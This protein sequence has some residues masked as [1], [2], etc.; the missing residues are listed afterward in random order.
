MH[1]LY[2]SVVLAGSS[3]LASGYQC[4]G[5]PPDVV[6]QF[7]PKIVSDEG[8]TTVH[9][10][11]KWSIFRGEEQI[12]G[13][14]CLAT[15]DCAE[16]QGQTKKRYEIEVTRTTPGPLGLFRYSKDT[17][18]SRD[19]MVCYQALGSDPDKCE[20][21]RQTGR[22][23]QVVE[24]DVP[25]A[26]APSI[27]K[28]ISPAKVTVNTLTSIEFT[29]AS[30]GDKAAFID[31][32]FFPSCDANTALSMKDVGTGHAHFSLK[33][34]EYVLCYRAANAKDAVMQA[35]ITLRV[36]P[37]GVTSDMLNLWQPA[38]GKLDCSQLSLAPFCSFLELET[39][40]QH[41][42]VYK[43]IG[44]RCRIFSDKYP[45]MCDL[46]RATA[47]PDDICARGKCEGAPSVCW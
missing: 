14:I 2:A 41:Y 38:A 11:G 27:V 7:S 37:P 19:M 9:L 28:S 31:P 3:W 26:T 42:S 45:S 32:T 17:G 25:P 21:T 24:A 23:F 20:W 46:N 10:F 29:G 33:K 1:F 36:R 34:G 35:G 47:T 5:K 30:P 18:D 22:L 4:V 43:G 8:T 39:C 40:E 12:G 15:T 16:C 6:Q 44:Y 13:R